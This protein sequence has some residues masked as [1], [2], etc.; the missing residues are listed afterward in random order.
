MVLFRSI[1]VPQC[2]NRLRLFT[3][4]ASKSAACL[5]HQ[6]QHRRALA[7]ADLTVLVAKREL[8]A[9]AM[10]TAFVNALITKRTAKR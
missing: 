5:P 9:V 3:L 10:Q 2:S 8:V 7:V 4:A 1:L 6:D